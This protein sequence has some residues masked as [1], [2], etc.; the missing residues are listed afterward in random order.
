MHRPPA[1]LATLAPLTLSAAGLVV[2]FL[3][4]TNGPVVA[5]GLAVFVVGLVLGAITMRSTPW[6]HSPADRGRG[7]WQLL[8]A[9]PVIVAAVLL[10]AQAGVEAWFV[11]MVCVL[12]AIG[13]TALGVG[14]GVVRLLTR[15]QL[16]G[17][18]ALSA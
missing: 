16:G 17:S 2:A 9:G 5:S 6:Q 8:L 13:L 11:G 1:H 12:L 7:W 10:A 18:G 3:G 14:L 15:R 4:G